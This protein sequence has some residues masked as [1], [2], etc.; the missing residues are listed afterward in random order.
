MVAAPEKPCS[1]IASEFW[2]M[3]GLVTA[4]VFAANRVIEDGGSLSSDVEGALIELRDVNMP[5]LQSSLHA[6]VSGT[7]TSQDFDR[8]AADLRKRIR[9]AYA[10]LPEDARGYIPM[11]CRR[12]LP[13]QQPL[14]G[15]H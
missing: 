2:Q 9:D 13:H 10:G 3:S 15:S 4:L 6:A 11:Q 1:A 12:L 8:L 14:Y 7:G 5:R